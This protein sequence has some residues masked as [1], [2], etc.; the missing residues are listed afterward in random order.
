MPTGTAAPATAHTLAGNGSEQA[1]KDRPDRIERIRYWE[2]NKTGTE[3]QGTTGDLA[4]NY[5]VACPSKPFCISPSVAVEC[6]HSRATR[7]GV[8]GHTRPPLVPTVAA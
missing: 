6:A 7:N 2:C 8:V 5:L 1:D 3:P 4:E